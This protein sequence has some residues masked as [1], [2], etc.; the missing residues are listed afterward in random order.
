MSGVSKHKYPR[1]VSRREF[2]LTLA[3]LPN[4]RLSAA[5]KT[6]VNAGQLLTRRN[7][8]TKDYSAFRSIFGSCAND[9]HIVAARSF[10]TRYT[11]EHGVWNNDLLTCTGYDCH[12]DPRLWL[13][14]YLIQKN[15]A[16]ERFDV[17]QID[18]YML[19][20]PEIALARLLIMSDS[21]D[22]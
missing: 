15:N 19:S 18:G 9:V 8:S 1:W 20:P 13:R 21:D 11:N 17:V 3:I 16:L 5:D 2:C 14:G 4:L 7:S 10:L 6:E 12:A 22:S